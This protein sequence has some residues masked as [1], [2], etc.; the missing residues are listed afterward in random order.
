MNVSQGALGEE[1]I[2]GAVVV[3]GTGASN[4]DFTI[5]ER[6]TSY[7]TGTTSGTM[8]GI[9]VSRGDLFYR[10]LNSRVVCRFRINSISGNTTFVGFKSSSTN[11]EA[12]DV[13]SGQH[14]IGVGFKSN[15]SGWHVIH[16]DGNG[17]ATT[18]AISP[19]EL[20]DTD[21]HML[22]IR[23]VDISGRFDI[24]WDNNNVQNIT[25]TYLTKALGWHL[26]YRLETQYLRLRLLT[27]SGLK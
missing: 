6:W 21:V 27:P 18:T 20:R 19:A 12:D 7:S 5:K 11:I 3:S 1:L 10:G 14:G 15:Q 26:L 13:L 4:E 16:N 22:D 23:G 2:A 9:R 8:A 24:R 17:A 25:K